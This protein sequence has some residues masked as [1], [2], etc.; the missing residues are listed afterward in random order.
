MTDTDRIPTNLRLLKIVEIMARSDS[1]LSPSEINREIGLPK[2]SIHR[3]CQTLQ[4]EGYLTR[5]AEPKKLRLTRRVREMASRIL[6]SN[7]VRIGR[8]QVLV[9]IARDL[10]ETVNFVVPEDQGMR[11][12]DRVEAEWPLRVQLPIGTH[13]PFHCTASGKCFLAS[14]KPKPLARMLAGLD[15]GRLTAKTIT[16]QDKLRAEIRIIRRTGFSTDR[17]EFIDDM[18]AVAV[19]V[20][21]PDGLFLGALAAHG[22]ASRLNESRFE[23]L[24]AALKSG[25]ERVAEQII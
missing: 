4:D 17:E 12:V 15:L 10:R 20:N 8:H 18:K 7:H 23:D 11:Y 1:P 3:L 21:G 25:A 6:A 5:D 19:P 9:S 2:A 14:L 13:V 24:A 16:D 22:P